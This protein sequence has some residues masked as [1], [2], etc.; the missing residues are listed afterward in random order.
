VSESIQLSGLTWY[1]AADYQAVKALMVD[2][3]RFPST[4]FQWTAKA[5]ALEARL[6]AEGDV[7]VRVA[8]KPEEFRE[9]CCHL[10]L[11]PN[12]FGRDLHAMRGALGSRRGGRTTALYRSL[13]SP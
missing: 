9:F 7:V 11:S 3:R 2:R 12:A 5:L 1:D 4:H 13:A 8:L 10:S 6:I